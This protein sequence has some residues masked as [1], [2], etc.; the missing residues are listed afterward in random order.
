L[1][2]KSFRS[3]GLAELWERGRTGKIGA[4]MHQRILR[5][6][7]RLD[8]VLR[9]EEMNIPGFDRCED[10]NRPAIRFTSTDHGASRLNSP[11]VTPA[12]WTSSNITKGK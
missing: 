9:P 7:D 11:T 8:A 6:L 1:V 5:R 4:K 12:A 10:F 3:K 2:I